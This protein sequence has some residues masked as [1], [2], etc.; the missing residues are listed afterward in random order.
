MS[1]FSSLDFFCTQGQHCHCMIQCKS[2]FNRVPVRR[3]A[4]TMPVDSL[5][6]DASA[7]G[8]TKYLITRSCFVVLAVFS[9][10]VVI[11]FLPHAR[12]STVRASSGTIDAEQC[13]GDATLRHLIVLHRHGVLDNEAYYA[14]EC[15]CCS[16]ICCSRIFLVT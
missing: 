11:S 12:K 15:V 7:K 16:Q 4:Y 8:S 13:A 14:D 5:S 1:R 2:R 6:V 9:L 10:I 3:A